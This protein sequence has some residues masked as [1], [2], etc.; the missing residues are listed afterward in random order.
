MFQLLNLPTGEVFGHKRLSGIIP[1]VFLLLQWLF[2]LSSCFVGHLVKPGQV[3]FNCFLIGAL[4]SSARRAVQW[5]W[6]MSAE[7]SVTD[8][9][10]NGVKNI[11][12]LGS[13]G[14]S[15]LKVY[16]DVKYKLVLLLFSFYYISLGKSNCFCF[17]FQFSIAKAAG[18]E[19]APL[20]L[21]QV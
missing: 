2:S 18:T 4:L 6:F 15:K 1:S 17:S 13:A 16:I 7:E 5:I 12:G 19:E 11:F 3:K 8:N 14:K 9:H 20:L 21:R 10:H